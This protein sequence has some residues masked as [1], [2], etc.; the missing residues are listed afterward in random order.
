MSS[1]ARLQ[2][3]EEK[4][5]SV[6][7]LVMDTIEAWVQTH[8]LLCLIIFIAILISLFV[9]LCFAIVGVSATDSGVVYNQF[10]NI[11]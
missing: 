5:S 1:P 6:S 3:K 4:S 10:N 11:I 8:A 2:R 7:Q 9:I